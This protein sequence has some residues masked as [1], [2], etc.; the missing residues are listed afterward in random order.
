MKANARSPSPTSTKTP[1]SRIDEY[2][3][4]FRIFRI[5]RRIGSSE[6]I[7][8]IIMQ[9]VIVIGLQRTPPFRQTTYLKDAV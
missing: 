5:P 2:R 9:I 3:G 4:M 1:G 7:G 8:Y 6:M